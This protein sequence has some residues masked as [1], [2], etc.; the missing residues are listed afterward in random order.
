MRALVTGGQG[1]IG[2]E[3]VRSWPG[4][5]VN[6]DCL[7]YAANPAYTAGREQF[8]IRGDIRDRELVGKVFR[9]Y[10]PELVVHF[11]AE[12][13]VDRSVDRPAL[14]VDTNVFGTLV[15]L[16]AARDAGAPFLHVSTDEVYGT[17][18]GEPF[19]EGTPYA[20]N[21]PYAASKAAADHLVRSF[22]TSY[23]LPTII[24]HCGNNYGPCQHEEKLI[25]KMIRRAQ[26]GQ[27]LPMHGDGSQVRDWIHVADHCAAIRAILAKG[28]WGEVYNIGAR[29][30]RT[31]R[32]VVEAICRLLGV[33]PRWQWV[34][35]RYC[36]DARY[37][38]NP[39][40]VEA[41]GWLPVFDFESNLA[42]TVRWYAGDR[43]RSAAA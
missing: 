4:E 18:T 33:A 28:T 16:E 40:K 26:A 39:A 19:H 24:T 12:S 32:E 3:F 13:H 7:T 29:S 35:D 41:L 23:G 9:T 42:D 11:A 17:C 27:L 38:I 37:A 2:S 10:R 6:L 36:Q 21:N 5:V 14:F 34:D 8:F 15:L 1:F 20:P 30:E 31:N 22:G 25:P 43:A